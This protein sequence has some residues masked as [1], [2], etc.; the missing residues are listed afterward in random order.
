M[1]QDPPQENLPQLPRSHLPPGRR[2][3]GLL[4]GLAIIIGGG[5]ALLW[6]WY[7]GR[8]LK[9][10]KNQSVY[11]SGRATP[12]EARALGEA[13][14]KVGWFDDDRQATALLRKDKTGTTV[15]LV[16]SPESWKEAQAEE[17]F[18]E[19]GRKIAPSVG[20]PPITLDL[21]DPY[22]RVKKRIRID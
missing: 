17:F 13:L 5:L 4:I 3:V 8:E 18:R 21:V 12:D 7:P 20:D 10:N 19:L 22:R 15:S 14:R 9:L 16:T 11:Y 2:L 1:P 6:Y